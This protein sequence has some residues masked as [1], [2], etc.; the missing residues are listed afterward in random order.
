MILRE[1]V[2]LIF[3]L[4]IYESNPDSNQLSYFEL[5]LP[6]EL[7][8]LLLKLKFWENRFTENSSKL[9]GL[10]RFVEARKR[11]MKR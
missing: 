2:F 9:E 7:F 11:T 4:N 1:A 6:L 10:D 3:K 5:P 8:L